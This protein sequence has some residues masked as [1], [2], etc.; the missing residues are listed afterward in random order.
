MKTDLR[1]KVIRLAHAKPEL[2]P[3][4]LPLIQKQAG[5]SAKDLGPELIGIIGREMKKRRLVDDYMRGDTYENIGDLLLAHIRKHPDQIAKMFAPV[6]QNFQWS[7]WENRGG[8]SKKAVRYPDV[9]GMTPAMS[10]RLVVPVYGGIQKFDPDFGGRTSLIVGSQIINNFLI[11]QNP[12]H[13][14]RK[15]SDLFY[16]YDKESKYDARKDEFILYVDVFGPVEDYEESAVLQSLEGRVEKD[17]ADAPK[18]AD[19]GVREYLY[20]YYSGYGLP[21]VT[22]AAIL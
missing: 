4:L 11:D 22:R 12:H 10:A 18:Y 21:Q 17:L 14:G 6:I 8:G 19:K 9:R 3:H 7:A 1:K 15:F 13:M 5:H 20:G 16:A 2:R